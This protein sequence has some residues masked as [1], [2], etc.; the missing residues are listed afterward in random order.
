[1]LF[2]GHSVANFLLFS[3]MCKNCAYNNHSSMQK[4]L[5]CIDIFRAFSSL[6]FKTRQTL[7]CLVQDRRLAVDKLAD[8]WPRKL[9]ILKM[10]S[11]ATLTT[12]LESTWFSIFKGAL[13]SKRAAWHGTLLFSGFVHSYKS[14]WC[15]QRRMRLEGLLTSAVRQ[16]PFFHSAWNVK[17]EQLTANINW[18]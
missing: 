8:Q 1:M 9:V 18:P 13:L 14:L 6:W 2:S 16:R 17:K 11:T 4:S 12:V 10:H 3:L 7:L 15:V 5:R